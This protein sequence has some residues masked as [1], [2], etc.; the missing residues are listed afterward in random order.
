VFSTA[1]AAAIVFFSTTLLILIISCIS[2]DNSYDPVNYDRIFLQNLRNSALAKIDAGFIERIRGILDSLNKKI[3]ADTVENGRRGTIN[4]AR[5]IENS[6]DSLY[7]I[8]A[9]EKNA[10]LPPSDTNYQKKKNLDTLSW[11]L[12]PDTMPQLSALKDSVILVKARVDTIIDTVNKHTDRFVIFSSKEHDELLAPYDTLVNRIDALKVLGLS[13]Y[14]LAIRENVD[15]I[16]P[17]NNAIKAENAVIKA[18]NDSLGRNTGYTIL[19]TDTASIVTSLLNAVAGN[20]FLLPN[21]TMDLPALRFNYSGTPSQ[22]IIIKGQDSTQFNISDVIL[23]GNSYITFIGIVFYGSTTQSVL[24]Q[25]GCTGIIFQKCRF[26]ANNSK[27]LVIRNSNVTLNDCSLKSNGGD[28]LSIISTPAEQHL[29][30]LNNVLIANNG[31]N[32]ISASGSRLSVQLTTIANHDNQAIYLADS[33]LDLFVANSLITNNCG[34]TAFPAIF[35][36]TGFTGTAP[37]SIV[38]TNIV[39]NGAGRDTV[40][41]PIAT[42]ILHYNPMYLNDDFDISPSSK[43]D[44]L[45]Q[46]GIIIGFRKW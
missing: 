33:A 37:V 44:S 3:V 31:G 6:Q 8:S 46:A 15:S 36:A 4:T 27:G 26:E 28:A 45:E 41:A 29:V 35:Y 21:T 24:V 38:T 34:K 19:T 1:R 20:K 32:A 7:N 43:I 25:N 23:N 11:L 39:Q 10:T 13:M 17:Y 5:Q 42:T 30:S 2:R 18:Y 9:Q 16:I 14:T 40:N 12:L 22:P